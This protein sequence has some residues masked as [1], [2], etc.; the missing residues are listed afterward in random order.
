MKP[1]LVDLPEAV[2]L[3]LPVSGL[4]SMVAAK[5][6][7]EYIMHPPYPQTRAQVCRDYKGVYSACQRLPIQQFPRFIKDG[8][9]VI[10]HFYLNENTGNRFPK[11]MSPA[12]KAQEA[13]L[14]LS[15]RPHVDME[16][17]LGCEIEYFIPR[18]M[19]MTMDAQHRA[20]LHDLADRSALDIKAVWE[21]DLPMVSNRMCFSHE[22]LE[23]KQSQD[24]TILHK[25]GPGVDIQLT[26]NINV[27]RTEFYFDASALPA[28]YQLYKARENIVLADK[29][30]VEPVGL[31]RYDGLFHGYEL[32]AIEQACDQNQLDS[33]SGKLKP[34]TSHHTV[35]NGEC[36]RTKHFFSTRYL[37]T[38]EQ[39]EEPDC[40]RA[41][42]LRADV[43][44]IP[45]WVQFVIERLVLLGVVPKDFINS[46]AMNMY[47]DGTIG[48]GLHT[49]CGSRFNRPIITLRLFSP[50]RLSLGGHHLGDNADCVVDL[51]RGTVLSM[52]KDS[53]AADGVKHSI[54]S[55]DLVTKSGALILRHCWDDCIEEAKVMLLETAAGSDPDET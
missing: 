29:C 23:L 41:G 50:A 25:K 10:C 2:W 8:Y 28:T 14:I 4:S 39:L 7:D 35:F 15:F 6:H 32:Q 18:I 43:D 27:N 40:D 17:R 37:W 47:H 51:P 45:A 54:R 31:V 49:D 46:V 42:G 11:N 22:M 30:E 38:K 9:I 5:L 55:C 19:W 33:E 52:Q 26:S 24:I 48:I 36:R 53:F 16:G 21:N 12:Q 44:P 13:N 3:A 34:M 20:N 1:N